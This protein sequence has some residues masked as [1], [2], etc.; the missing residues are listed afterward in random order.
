M[1]CYF[2]QKKSILSTKILPIALLNEINSVEKDPLIKTYKK[3]GWG[4]F[5]FE[6]AILQKNQ[7][8]VSSG[9]YFATSYYTTHVI[10]GMGQ[11]VLF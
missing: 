11:K 7:P 8:E 9:F 6:D 3:S 4:S 2:L 5:L 1:F 10:Y